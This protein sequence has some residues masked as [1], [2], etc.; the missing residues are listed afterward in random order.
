MK[1][2]DDKVCSSRYWISRHF[3]MIQEKIEQLT[4]L[5]PSISYWMQWTETSNGFVIKRD[6]GNI[7][8]PYSELSNID[9]RLPGAIHCLKNLRKSRQGALSDIE[10]TLE[11]W[12]TP[13]HVVS[14]TDKEVAMVDV[15]SIIVKNKTV[16]FKGNGIEYQTID[17]PRTNLRAPILV[18][19]W[20]SHVAVWRTWLDENFPDWNKRYLTA[21]DLGLDTKTSAHYLFKLHEPTAGIADL[22][23]DFGF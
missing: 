15:T 13:I 18:A 22:P 3:I 17:I 2:V 4:K 5:V 23:E 1:V 19:E 9:V 7:T 21:Q 6:S 10:R 16:L 12:D 11:L 14:S 20:I 8:I